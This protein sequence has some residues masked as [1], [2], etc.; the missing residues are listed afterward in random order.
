MAEQDESLDV[1]LSKLL[2]VAVR[3][4]W[5]L[6]VPTVVVALGA[7]A[8]SRVLPNHYESVAT[9]LVAH[10]Q[11]PE[12]YVT[13]NSTADI[14][15]Q[16][17]LMTDTILSRTQLI[18]IIGEFDLY[19]RARKRLAPEDLVELM[20]KD[21]T[22]EP[23]GKGTETKEPNS[24]KISFTGTDPHMAQEVTSKL[25]TLFTQEYLESREDQSK[26]TTIFLGDQLQAADADLKQQESRLRDFKMHYLGELPEQQ[27]GNL[28]ILAGLH[29]ELQ[30]TMT[31]INRARQQQ[32]YLESL[33]SQY[34]SMADAG[35]AAPGAVVVSP[36]D[37]IKAELTQ[38][39]NERADLLARYTEKYP[40]VVK[41]DEQI[42]EAE[43]MLAAATKGSAPT[44]GETTKA[45]AKS[46]NPSEKDAATAQLKS[47]LEANR[48]EIQDALADQKQIESR[49]A[50][51]QSR[52][53]M[54]PVREEQLADILRDYDL[55]KKN[56]DDL[57]AKEKQSELATSLEIRQE[58][59]QFRLIDPP[60]LPMKPSGAT[61]V[62][63]SLGGLGAGLALGIA[64]V[65]LLET[66]DH[67]LLDEEE[68]RRVFAFPLLVGV[69]MLLSK[70][71]QRRRSRVAVL[72][73][74]V[75]ATLCLL[76]C[77]T[78]FYVYRRG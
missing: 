10:Q 54:T 12:R 42:K 9:I 31:S 23:T 5:W 30:N 48:L 75:G 65:F 17:L 4:R 22:I 28:A 13:P 33:L 70:V 41:I 29:T 11:V 44:K 3:R 27:Q 46:A 36:A 51:Y 68:L 78:E 14:R 64:L 25:T 59:A 20:R 21:I 63:V 37:T 39:R 52:L 40:D 66:K 49:I 57:L 26:R 34:Q 16:L 47:Q 74:L 71:E 76:V 43:A 45:S 50:E 32:V 6:L 56:Y 73:W 55:S 19:P 2:H 60:S 72:E 58:G 53:N 18:Q 67:S 69:P 62:K 15:E 35:V 38:L 8:V 77:A 1:M 24:F 61:H 7:C